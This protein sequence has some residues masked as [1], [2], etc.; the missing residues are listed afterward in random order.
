MIESHLQLSTQLAKINR[1]T[2]TI[3]N[4]KCKFDSIYDFEQQNKYS[5]SLY[6]QISQASKLVTT[7]NSDHLRCRKLS[8]N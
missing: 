5:Q 2:Q 4:M 8:L 7:G 1:V 3:G 6:N